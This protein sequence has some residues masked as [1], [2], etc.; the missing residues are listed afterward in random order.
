MHECTKTVNGVALIKMGSGRNIKSTTFTFIVLK[1]ILDVLP[2]LNYLTYC[3]L[4]YLYCF[5]IRRHPRANCSSQVINLHF[6]LPSILHFVVLIMANK[7]L[8]SILNI[9]NF[10]PFIAISLTVK[11]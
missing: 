1:F 9:D 2:S 4:S 11:N 3:Y 5:W 7:I 10:T 6:C 8:I